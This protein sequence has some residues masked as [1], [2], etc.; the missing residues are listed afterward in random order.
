MGF[1]GPEKLPTVHTSGLH[2]LSPGRL[3]AWPSYRVCG[4]PFVLQIG[5]LEAGHPK[6]A[7]GSPAEAALQ[8]AGPKRM[9]ITT[10]VNIGLPE[11]EGSSVSG[12]CKKKH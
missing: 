8:A 6:K 2:V 7:H 9:L 1:R 4:N 3:C 5:R 10:S 11:T 12:T